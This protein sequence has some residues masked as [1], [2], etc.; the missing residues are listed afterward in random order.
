M[1]ALAL[2]SL[3]AI[4]F[5]LPGCATTSQAYVEKAR[6]FAV[7]Q[8]RIRKILGL[9]SQK[10][11]SLADGVAIRIDDNPCRVTIDFG[12]QQKDLDLPPGSVLLL[13]EDTGYV[14]QPHGDTR[15]SN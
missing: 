7:T 8:G 6:G 15:P 13:A 3:L 2:A 1:K 4:T 10:Y 12:G 14:M 11:E 5:F 9:S